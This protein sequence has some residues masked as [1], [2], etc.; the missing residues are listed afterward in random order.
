[1][2]KRLG[3]KAK[4]MGQAA[5]F[6]KTYSPFQH[7]FNNNKTPILG[8]SSELHVHIPNCLKV[9]STGMSGRHST[10]HCPK[11]DIPLCSSLSLHYPPCL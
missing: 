1:M 3:M 2:D 11:P 8:L 5:L 9:T 4:Q 6:L 10:A 7:S